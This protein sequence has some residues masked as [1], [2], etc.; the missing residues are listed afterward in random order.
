MACTVRI[1]LRS[2][3]VNDVTSSMAWRRSLTIGKSRR[4]IVTPIY[5]TR[6]V[7]SNTNA[8]SVGDKYNINDKPT[9]IEKTSVS[10]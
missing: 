2:S 10:T 7:G 4:D 5:A 3:D 1:P 9:T 8:V 6:G